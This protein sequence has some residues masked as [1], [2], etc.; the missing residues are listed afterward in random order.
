MRLFVEE[1]SNFVAFVSLEKEWNDLLALAPS[2]A[3]FLRHEWFRVWWKAFGGGKRMAVLTVR[4]QEGRLL[5]VAPLMEARGIRTGVPCRIWASM[6]ND[7]SGRFDFI[8]SEALQHPVEAV[9][10]IIAYMER[11]AP[12]IHLMELQDLPADS[13]TIRLFQEVSVR[14]GRAIGLGPSIRTPYVP[15]EGTWSAYFDSL[16]GRLKRNLRRRRRQLEALG[17]VTMEQST[18]AEVEGWSGLA[19]RLREG[20][21]IEALAWKG[22]AGT[23]I[24]EN[25]TLTAFYREWAGLAAEQGWL[26]LYF[27]KLDERRIAFFYALQYGRT[28]YYLK[29]G[30]DPAF[31][32]Y[33]PGVLLHQEILKSLFEERLSE[34]DF[35]GPAMGWKLD[36]AKDVRPHV[37]FYSFQEGAVPSLVYFMKFKALPFLKRFRWAL[38]LQRALFLKSAPER[39]LKEGEKIGDE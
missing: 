32:R 31:A 18:G 34:L 9:E 25:K 35:L 30:Y 38:R 12:K 6:S 36:W 3:P 13:R 8:F 5:A 15:I 16:S 23:A 33:S 39:P 17:P 37:W 24:R 21:D 14:K 4:S 26:R 19:D 27:L 22:R 29:L 2:D 7:H 10:A 20:F 28:L 1:I 11:R